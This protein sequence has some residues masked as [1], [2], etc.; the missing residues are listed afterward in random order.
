MKVRA[1]V[2]WV[3]SYL[4]GDLVSVLSGVRWPADIP[5]GL[6]GDPS[7]YLC[8]LLHLARIVPSPGLTQV[9]KPF[10]ATSYPVSC[11]RIFNVGNHGKKEVLGSIKAPRELQTHVINTQEKSALF[12]MHTCIAPD[13]QREKEEKDVYKIKEG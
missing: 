3:S 4:Q 9:G 7:C 13:F 5:Q 1:S 10:C 8:Q 12:Y 2:F 6:S 11:K